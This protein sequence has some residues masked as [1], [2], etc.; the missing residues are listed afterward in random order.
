MEN[1]ISTW[2]PWR[3]TGG[4]PLPDR[5]QQAK[6][7]HA[8]L[9]IKAVNGTYAY[10][11]EHYAFFKVPP[12][13]GKSNDD[14]ERLAKQAGVGVDIWCYIYLASPEA[15]ARAVRDAVTHYN[16]QHCFIDVEHH[17]KANQANTGS[18]LRALGRLPCQVWLQSYRRPDF[19]P[20][21]QWAKWLT[22]KADGRFI[23]DGI[24]PQAYPIKS[25]D[26]YGDFQRMVNA[27]EKYLDIY[28][29]DPLPWFPTLPSFS[30][31]GW[32]PLASSY[33]AGIKYLTNR[34]QSRMKGLNHWRQGFLFQPAFSGI[35][36]HIID[37]GVFQDDGDAPPPPPLSLEEKV[38]RLWQVASEKGWFV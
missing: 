4:A 34:L 13:L 23:I 7:A 16:P 22:Y 3:L 32:T 5:V 10:G 14:L 35:L 19:H 30:E 33:D 36:Q 28:R 27:C 11:S 29:D 18:F 20:E 38:N 24:S 12:Y 9:C 31:W 17:A 15:E 1:L 2:Q 21:I 25:Q 8:R 37:F 6:D 26:F